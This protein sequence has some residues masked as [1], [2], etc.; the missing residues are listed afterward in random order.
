MNKQYLIG[1]RV[2]LNKTE[3][4]TIVTPENNYSKGILV[5]SPSYGYASCYS[6]HNV[7][8]LPN[9]KL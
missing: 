1:Q 4:G 7:K 2:I 5:Y 9:W 3:I 6:E 8:P